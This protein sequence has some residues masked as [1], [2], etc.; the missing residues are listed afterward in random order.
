[1][2]KPAIIHP[3]LHASISQLLYIFLTEKY[4]SNP[5]FLGLRNFS[6]AEL[7]RNSYEI[8][9]DSFYCLYEKNYNLAHSNS[10]ATIK[11]YFCN[12]EF[13]SNGVDFARGRICTELTLFCKK[14]NAS[15]LVN[16]IEL[17]FNESLGFGSLVINK[18]LDLRFGKLGN[19]KRRKK[20]HLTGISTDFELP[21]GGMGRQV[22]TYA[23]RATKEKISFYRAL[24]KFNDEP[25]IREL[26]MCVI[27]NFP[28]AISPVEGLEK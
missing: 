20:F 6:A 16:S 3:V 26:V 18:F 17:F 14:R 7:A 9:G 15:T 8:A 4:I 10:S 11:N 21:S 27:K 24:K 23:V 1:M 19:E 2:K 25:A 28:H 13:I 5:E 22:N 12:G